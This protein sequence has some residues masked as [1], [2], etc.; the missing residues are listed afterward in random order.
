[1]SE[2]GLRIAVAQINV[3]V[4]DLRGNV[5]LILEGLARARECRAEVVLFPELPITGYPAED[6]YLRPQFVAEAL[7]ALRDIAPATKG[8]TALVGYPRLDNG[9][10]YNM[11]GIL[12]D[13]AL[14]CE[15]A[16]ICLP[17][18]GVFD[19]KRYFTP[20]REALVVDRNGVKLGISV[21]EDIWIAD[22]VTETLAYAGGAQAI[23]NVSCSPF[24]L[25]KSR[26]RLEMMATRAR[27]CGVFLVNCNLVGGQDDLVF[28]GQSLVYD[29]RGQL[30]A[31][32]KPFA[33]DFF[34]IDIDIG[35]VQRLRSGDA[36]LSKRAKVFKA[37]YNYAEKKLSQLPGPA[38]AERLTPRSMQVDLTEEEEI[39][40]ALLRGTKDYAAKNDFENVVLGLS[41]GIDSAVVAA[42]A[43]LALG[44]KK[45]HAVTM[46]TEYTSALSLRDA[47]R[48]AENLGIV[49]HSIPIQKVFDISK[50]ML[51]PLFYDRD[52]DITEENLQAR[53][54]GNVLM[55]LA[56]KFNW[57][58]L[59]CGNKSEIGVGYCTLYGDTAGGFAVIR[60]VPKTMVYRIAEYINRREGKEI[61]PQSV[62][63]KPPSA[64]LKPGQTDQDLLPPYDI[65]DPILEAY[66]EKDRSIAEIVAAGFDVDIVRRVVYLL[67]KSEYKRRQAAPGIKITRRGFDKGWRMPLT[68]HYRENT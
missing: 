3:T 33:P 25:G 41:G 56:N 46:P 61:L 57:L 18:Y 53:I 64:E 11:M 49:L 26:E 7:S 29:P 66:V 40:Q 38:G 37:R 62:L 58:V 15:Y 5:D 12:H 1:M 67:T 10:L 20:G 63:E 52:E 2:Q 8:L 9:A 6:L 28:D 21:C 44:P 36:E 24:Q 23:L 19:E 39:L 31:R 59:V 68:N 47:Q 4:G 65:L 22:G 14:A 30:L 48:I 51:F 32:G 54:R 16:K 42:I 55:A 27:A 43:A 45:V 13:G 34:A 60:D 50:E 17:N 35:E